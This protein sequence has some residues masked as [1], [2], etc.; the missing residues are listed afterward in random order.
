M[1]RSGPSSTCFHTIANSSTE[2]S[3]HAHRF[4][5]VVAFFWTQIPDFSSDGKGLQGGRWFVCPMLS[6]GQSGGGDETVH[7]AM[8]TMQQ[9]LQGAGLINDDIF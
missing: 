9:W 1:E 6:T 3:V 2:C 8:V 4:L 7:L 5:K